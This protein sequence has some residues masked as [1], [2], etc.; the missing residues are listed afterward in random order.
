LGGGP[1]QDLRRLAENL[2]TGAL[3]ILVYRGSSWE[4]L[5]EGSCELHSLVAPRDLDVSRPT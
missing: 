1:E 3:A 5:G 2:P 4:E